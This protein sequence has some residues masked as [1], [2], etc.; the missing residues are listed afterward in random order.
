MEQGRVDDVF[1]HPQHPYTKGL[2]ESSPHV[3]H[4]DGAGGGQVSGHLPTIPGTVPLPAG[5]PSGCRFAERCFQAESRCSES[6]VA[7][8]ISE[9][10]EVRC[11]KILQ[12]VTI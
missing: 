11:L 7:L 1:I 8:T 5:W 12:G 2:L 4:V 9:S 3:E 6:R 10:R